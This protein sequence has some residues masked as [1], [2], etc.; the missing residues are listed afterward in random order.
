MI[1]YRY[2]S[3]CNSV[4]EAYG[5]EKVKKKNFGQ[6]AEGLFY[7]AKIN[8]LTSMGMGSWW[9]HVMSLSCATIQLCEWRSGWAANKY[10]VFRQ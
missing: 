6:L 4:E 10:T 8:Y 9:K 5:Q 7:Y 1:A 3:Q 2:D